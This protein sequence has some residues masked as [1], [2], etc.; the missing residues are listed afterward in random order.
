M[1]EKM[2]R[3]DFGLT[4]ADARYKLRLAWSFLLFAEKQF[5][6]PHYTM[7]ETKGQATT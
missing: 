1:G 6:V 4:N 3:K 5:A 2:T 7:I